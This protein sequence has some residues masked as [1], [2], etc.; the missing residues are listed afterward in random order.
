MTDMT[1]QRPQT[2]GASEHNNREQ[3]PDR[4]LSTLSVAPHF[5]EISSARPTAHTSA[6]VAA[7]WGSRRYDSGVFIEGRLLGR[8][9]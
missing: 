7:R 3:G 5:S 9:K 1:H 4:G 6:S 8:E 2:T